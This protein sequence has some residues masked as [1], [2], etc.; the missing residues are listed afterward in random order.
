M[1]DY[2]ANSLA[3]A[4]GKPQPKP[5]IPLMLIADR[6]G[7]TVEGY[8]KS[9][10]T[11]IENNLYLRASGLGDLCP[12]HF[13]LNY[14]RPQPRAAVG[15]QNSLFMDMGTMLHS[16]LQDFLL[17]PAGILFGDWQHVETGEI[18]KDC[19]WPGERPISLRNFREGYT[20]NKWK[21]VEKTLVD[22]GWRIAGHCDGIIHLDRLAAYDEYVNKKLPF[23]EIVRKVRLVSEA[24]PQALLEVKTTNDRIFAGMAS[25]ADLSHAYAT[26]ATVYQE[27]LGVKHTMFWILNRNDFKTKALIY[28]KQAVKWDEVRRKAQV[29]WEAI[30]DETLPDS[31]MPC[32][33]AQSSR[34]KDCS[35]ASTCWT[36]KLDFA[37]FV[38]QSKLLQPERNWMDLTAWQPPTPMISSP[39]SSPLSC[40]L[41]LSL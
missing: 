31:M 32:A 26:Q 39:D 29:V 27:L 2:L 16:Y 7:R 4:I 12:R 3:A 25:S 38:A 36:S 35:T 37:S 13:V 15:L 23:E 22:P 17:G 21:Y 24:G 1:S 28:E 9:L 11:A 8:V 40:T 6:W 41:D 19:Y 33:S 34:A 14:W 18:Q 5:Q 30:R 10:E 20:V